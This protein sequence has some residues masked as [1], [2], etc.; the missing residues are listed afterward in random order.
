MPS[1]SIQ[2]HCLVKLASMSNGILIFFISG[3]EK[4]KE[5]S[6][7]LIVLECHC[8]LKPENLVEF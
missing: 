4:E 2:L 3:E 6:H 1:Y 5:K 8:S 7:Q